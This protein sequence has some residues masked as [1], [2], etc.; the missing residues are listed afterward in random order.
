V[1]GAEPARQRHGDALVPVGAAEVVD[2]DGL[3]LVALRE[4]G[5]SV[6]APEPV[7]Q[8]RGDR[9]GQ[10]VDDVEPGVV[11]RQHRGAP[12]LVTE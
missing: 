3:V 8:R 5:A 1:L 10:D 6:Q 11:A 12:F 7:G 4:V 2:E 9:L